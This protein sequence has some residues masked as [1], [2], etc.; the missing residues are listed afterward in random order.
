[1][2]VWLDQVTK[3]WHGGLAREGSGTPQE[4]DGG[5]GGEKYS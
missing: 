1:M 3:V 4:A 5:S 2:T